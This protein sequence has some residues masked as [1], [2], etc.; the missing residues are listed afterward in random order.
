MFCRP[1]GRPLRPP[2]VLDRLHRLSEETGAPWVTVH[3]LRHLAATITII[4][5]V[6][7]TVVSKTLRHSTPSTTANRYSHFSQQAAHQ[8]V[9]HILSGAE[10]TVGR[11][12][13][14]TWL[15][16]PRDRIHRLREALHRI[17][18]PAPP[19]ANTWANQPRPG[20]ATTLQPPRLQTRERPPSH[21]T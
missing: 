4:A 21:E 9:D 13:R 18:S 7:L 12:G 5:G 10:Q 15:R 19:A 2:L 6:P 20:R 1:D 16:P 14:P 17:R 11:T 3:D 8:A